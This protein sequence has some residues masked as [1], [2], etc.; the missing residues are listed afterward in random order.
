MRANNRSSD[1]RVIISFVYDVYLPLCANVPWQSR[2]RALDPSA[3]EDRRSMPD[4]HDAA[5]AIL[6]RINQR[7]EETQT[8]LARESLS[9]TRAR[10]TACYKWLYNFFLRNGTRSV[11][12]K[13]LHS[14]LRW[15]R[16][17]WYK[18]IRL[19]SRFP[20]NFII[21]VLAANRTYIFPFYSTFLRILLRLSK[22]LPVNVYYRVTWN[23]A[24]Y[25]AIRR[26]SMTFDPLTPRPLHL[27]RTSCDLREPVD[28]HVKYPWHYCY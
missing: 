20:R 11:W 23:I 25:F 24:I 9:K 3:I 15:I 26:V 21:A 13:T 28:E 14:S 1:W 16:R 2:Y 6:P 18:W 27:A 8:F 7:S 10:A 17:T 22:S 5:R 19:R 4:E 12:F